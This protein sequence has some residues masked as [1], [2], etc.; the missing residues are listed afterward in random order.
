MIPKFKPGDRLTAI[1][2]EARIRIIGVS[3]THYII[4][5]IGGKELVTSWPHHGVEKD[6]EIS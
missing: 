4:R 5:F 6:Y 2:S 1:F 3:K